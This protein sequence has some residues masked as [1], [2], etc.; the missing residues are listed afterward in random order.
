MRK[1]KK[2]RRVAFVLALGVAFV[3]ALGVTLLDLNVGFA[4]D[5]QPVDCPPGS[6]Y[7][8]VQGQPL[9]TNRIDG[10]AREDRLRGS[11]DPRVTDKMYGYGADDQ[12]YGSRG[13]DGMSGGDGQDT[14]YGG[15]G[16]DGLF[17][18][19]GIDTIYGGPGPD[20]IWAE[21]GEQDIISCG[22]GHDFVASDTIDDLNLENCE[23]T[24]S[25]IKFDRRFWARLM[26]K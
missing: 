1:E 25:D 24:P 21:D 10:T 7:E 4:Q 16:G 2:V 11:Q 5:A 15:R 8:E 17:G 26:G 13:D 3:L 12:L 22:P 6:T 23:P 18:D 9:C 19:A 14:L 20:D